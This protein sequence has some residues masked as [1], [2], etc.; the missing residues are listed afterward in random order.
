MKPL[1]SA[2]MKMA[3]WVEKTKTVLR[4][5]TK[6]GD[7]QKFMNFRNFKKLHV[8]SYLSAHYREMLIIFFGR[9]M[10]DCNLEKSHLSST[11]RAVFAPAEHVGNA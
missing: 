11:Q 10:A 9:F 1:D 3:L 2:G 6:K 7:S 4:I 8:F 5:C